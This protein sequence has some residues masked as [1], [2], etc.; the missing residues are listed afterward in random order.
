[1]HH[2][3]DGGGVA[4]GVDGVEMIHHRRGEAVRAGGEILQ[5][6][7]QLPAVGGA[8]VLVVGFGQGVEHLLAVGVDEAV[9][10]PQVEGVAGVE[11]DAGEAQEQAGFTGQAV[12]EPAG[13]HV[14]E[15]ADGDFR[16]GEPAFRGHQAELAGLHQAHAAAHDH[17][18]RPANHRGLG[19]VQ[20]MV[21]A[22]FTGEVV[23]GERVPA[24]P[25][26]L[27]HGAVQG[28]H[29]AAGAERLA[30]VAFQP[31]R[32]HLF[33][34]LPVGDLPVEG[35]DHFQAEGVERARR[36]ERGAADQVAAAGGAFFELYTVGHAERVLNGSVMRRFTGTSRWGPC[37]V[38]E[39]TGWRGKSAR[40][41]GNRD[42]RRAATGAAR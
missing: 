26:V 8:V 42:A 28:D 22:V 39:G 15:Q 27:D 30:A 38:A 20:A 40:S 13:A 2:F 29:I 14:R 5:G 16:H 4:E 32:H 36:V 31:D 19:G 41:P 24:L 17:A 12:E 37:L 25:G 35:F 11:V 1:M 21:E 3:V 10:E 9:G 7:V 18:V 23:L 33:A 34:G 6:A